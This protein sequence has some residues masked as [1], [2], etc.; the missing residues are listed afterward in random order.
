MFVKSQP[1]PQYEA[2]QLD[3]HSA[4]ERLLHYPVLPLNNII[5]FFSRNDISS[6]EIS[7]PSPHKPSLPSPLGFQ[8]SSL[9]LK[10]DAVTTLLRTPTPQVSCETSTTVNAPN[11]T[12][13]NL[14]VYPS[15]VMVIVYRVASDK[16]QHDLFEAQVTVWNIHTARNTLEQAPWLFEMPSLP[17]SIQSSSCL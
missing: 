7:P 4:I 6:E 13:I 2:S 11:R 17:F 15:C 10:C 5:V 16:L 14:M 9:R 1:G 12:P 3:H 8:A